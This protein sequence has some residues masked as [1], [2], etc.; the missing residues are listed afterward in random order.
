MNKGIPFNGFNSVLEML[1]HADAAFREK[2]LG[3]VRRRDPALAQRLE[4][5]LRALSSRDKD[6]RAAL[7]R[8]TRA[9][10]TRNYGL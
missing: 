10:Q 6:S 2:L 9:A 4:Q 8:G 5:E 1:R 3:N 7:E